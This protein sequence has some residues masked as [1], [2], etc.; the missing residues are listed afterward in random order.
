M[1]RVMCVGA[2]VAATRPKALERDGRLAVVREVPVLVCESCGEVYLDA[3]VA[4]Q[5]DVLFRRASWTAPSTRWSGTTSRPRR[6]A[7]STVLSA[8]NAGNGRRPTGHRSVRS[9]P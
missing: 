3:S 5:L 9:C 2:M 6:S 8:P 1:S 7:A 4:R